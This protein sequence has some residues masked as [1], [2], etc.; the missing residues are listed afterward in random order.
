MHKVNMGEVRIPN[1]M[2]CRKC[3]AVF[4]ASQGIGHYGDYYCILFKTRLTGSG[5]D[6]AGADNR[7]SHNRGWA[8]RKCEECLKRYPDTKG[9]DDDAG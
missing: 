7:W 6:K 3:G 8:A 2:N 1:G 4:N 5:Y 9:G